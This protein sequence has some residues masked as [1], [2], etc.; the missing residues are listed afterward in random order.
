MNNFLNKALELNTTVIIPGFGALTI[1]SQRT[2]DIYFIPYLKHDDGTLAKIISENTGNDF[3][4]SKIFLKNYVLEIIK[5]IESNSVFEIIEFGRFK[6]IHSGE[7]EFEKWEDY[8][9]PEKPKKS[10]IKPSNSEKQQIKETKRNNNPEL[11][12]IETIESIQ[13]NL[14]KPE[15]NQNS[16]EEILNDVTN[17]ENEI[18]HNEKVDSNEQIE[19]ISENL[20]YSNE[21]IQEI[22]E[23]N[24]KIIS[25]DES[26]FSA[27]E[28]TEFKSTIK[29]EKKIKKE[30]FISNSE[31]TVV[32]N[33]ENIEVIIK[34]KSKRKS[35]KNKQIEVLTTP[36]N[37]NIDHP[38]KK[39]NKL[40]PWLLIGLAITSGTVSYILHLR[41]NEKIIINEKVIHKNGSVEKEVMAEIVTEINPEKKLNVKKIEIKSKSNNKEND[42]NVKSSKE[43]LKKET[44]KINKEN[45]KITNKT[46]T[47]DNKHFK[48][49]ISAIVSPKIDKTAVTQ[50]T[51]NKQN[52]QNNLN[53]NYPTKPSRKE[54]KEVDEIVAK[55]NTNKKNAEVINNV[56][57]IGTNKTIESNKNTEV[58]TQKS[59]NQTIDISQ[60][61]AINS[62]SNINIDKK[63]SVQQVNTSKNT[64]NKNTTAL[65]NIGTT[66]TNNQTVNS[67]NTSISQKNISTNTSTNP[68]NATSKTLG[69][70]NT[71]ASKNTTQVTNISSKSP[72]ITA[73][74]PGG[75]SGN[76]I[77]LIAET[78]KD[79]TSAEKLVNKLKEG[80]YKNTRIDEK[81][82]Q[83]NVIIDNYNTLSETI[84]ELKK[85][86][87]Q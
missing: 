84:K 76:K 20:I 82:G 66:T 51:E 79:K 59:A 45:E 50:K 11:S 74:T 30:N 26:T 16:L 14:Y 40:L 37:E 1:T 29:K 55:L 9:K 57:T 3:E 64:T 85:Y 47:L 2:K 53:T 25:K 36:L 80:G 56:K 46:A 54:L 24:E 5:V 17:I 32:T 22:K 34:S 58:N 6:K 8:H 19:K 52:K 18:I 83:Y 43:T 87:S 81:D 21:F 77:E 4:S 38:K 12:Y 72:N 31:E 35:K 73:N 27:I 69:S 63:T 13:L 48:K 23:D 68:N 75:K 70:Q 62:K 49:P 71:S 42:E 28:S 44:K 78:F 61:N 39:K 33:S 15:I 86:R 7:I 65:N 41:K 67:K 10:K 60:N